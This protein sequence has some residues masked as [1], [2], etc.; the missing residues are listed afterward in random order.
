MLSSCSQDPDAPLQCNFT[1]GTGTAESWVSS[2]NLMISTRKVPSIAPFSI[3]FLY[4][5]GNFDKS[6]NPSHQPIQFQVP[7][8]TIKAELV[9]VITG[10]GNLQ[11]HWALQG[12]ENSLSFGFQITGSGTNNC[13]EFCPT[14]HYFVI[15]DHVNEQTFSNAGS[16]LGCADE[17]PQGNMPNQHGTWLYGR[18]GTFQIASY[19][20]V[21]MGL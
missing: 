1:I 13:A 21:C 19:R 9:T 16:A 4:Y 3:K 12:W 15:N 8:D 18:D 11:H 6:Y 7:Q 14:S 2:L 17:T 20:T 5:G 10:H